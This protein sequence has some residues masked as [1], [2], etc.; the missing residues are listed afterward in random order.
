MKKLLL[1]LTP[2]LLF[3]KV[4]YAKV[5]PFDTTVLKSSVSGLVVEADIRK[6][7]R[8]VKNG[9]IVHL[10]DSLDIAHL[11]T[12][13]DT[14]KLFQKMLNINANIAKSLKSTQNRQE[15]R[16]HRIN[17]LATASKTQKDNAYS[18]FISTKTKYLGTKEK[19][20]NLKKQLLD[21]NYRVKQLKDVISKKSLVLKDKYLYKLL[22]RKGDFVGAGSPLAKVMDISRGK[23]VLFLEA[24]EI[25][26]IKNKTVF[27]DGKETSYRVDKIWRVADEKFISSYRAEIY[28]KNPLNSFSKLKKVEIR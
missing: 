12:S 15:S 13:K 17:K 8:R 6:E 14:I 23:L 25:A 24:Q 18:T 10:D 9:R 2:I 28:I 5:E 3:S 22:V 4:H 1:L 7:G 21:L 19:I 26:D 20:V 16:Y 11:K 27:I